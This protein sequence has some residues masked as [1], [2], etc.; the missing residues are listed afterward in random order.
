MKDCVITDFFDPRFQT[1]FQ[2]YFKELEIKINNWDNLFDEINKEKDNV[3]I[4]RIA[5]D[6]KV[7]GFILFKIE[8]FKNWFFEEKI[9]FVRE[10]WISRGFRKKG[11]GSSLLNLAEKYFVKQEV[12][13]SILTTDTA[14]NFYIK[15][16]YIQDFSYSAKNKDQVFVKLLK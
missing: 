10:F 4:L 11:H 15:Q 9:G 6:N 3:A 8:I 7:I 2:E 13:K 1:A 12:Y 16:N 5:E 14:P